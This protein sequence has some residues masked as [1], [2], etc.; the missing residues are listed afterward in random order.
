MKDF[1]C[2]IQWWRSEVEIRTGRRSNRR[3]K[4]SKNLGWRRRAAG[5]SH[6]ARR[7]QFAA[8]SRFWSIPNLMPRSTV[9]RVW[10]TEWAHLGQLCGTLTSD[11]LFFFFFFFL[12]FRVCSLTRQWQSTECDARYMVQRKKFDVILRLLVDRYRRTK[13]PKSM[14]RRL[15]RC[16]SAT[17]KTGNRFGWSF[18]FAVWRRCAKKST[19]HEQRLSRGE[20]RKLRFGSNR[21]APKIWQEGQH[22]LHSPPQPIDWR[23]HTIGAVHDRNLPTRSPQVPE[24]LSYENFL[25]QLVKVRSIV[26]GL[27]HDDERD[28]DRSHRRIGIVSSLD[29]GWFR[30]ITNIL[31]QSRDLAMIARWHQCGTMTSQILA[32]ASFPPSV[33]PSSRSN[34]DLGPSPSDSTEKSLSYQ[35]LWFWSAVFL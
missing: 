11:N 8:A 31:I 13:Q 27:H 2:R 19:A 6:G 4:W 14:H 34:F 10:L 20:S 25:W 21:T 26:T 12:S 28:D 5:M 32:R 7:Q 16:S 15:I 29:A 30:L 35:S 24:S 1:F 33:W 18:F 22:D 17:S 23:E 3:S 9:T